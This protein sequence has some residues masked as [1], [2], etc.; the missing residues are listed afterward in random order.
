MPTYDYECKVCG[1]G[2]ETV[3]G[4]RDECFLIQCPHCFKDTLEIQ[5]NIAPHGFVKGEPKTLGLL[6][7]RNRSAMS[8]QEYEDK[9]RTNKE[10]HKAAIQARK[11]MLTMPG[12]NRCETFEQFEAPWRPGTVKPNMKLASLNE[13]QAEKYILEGEIK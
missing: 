1:F 5:Y 11:E 8:H 9:I 7:D 12:E 4:M 2:F 6:A 3:H 13:K 10:N